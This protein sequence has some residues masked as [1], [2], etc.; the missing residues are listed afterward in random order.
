MG[1]NQMIYRGAI[2][3]HSTHSYDGKST[4]NE[5]KKKAV[6]LGLDFIALTEHIENLDDESVNVYLRECE[7][8]SDE[9]FLI[10]PGFEYSEFKDHILAIGFKKLFRN[11]T[12]L[13]LI[14]YAK[15][16]D[17]IVILAHPKKEGYFVDS[18]VLEN[19]DGLEIWN[20]KYDGIAPNNKSIEI[21]NGDTLAFGGNDLHSSYEMGGITYEVDAEKLGETYILKALKMG[22]YTFGNFLFRV[23]PTPKK[24]HTYSI[25][26]ILN[27][28]YHKLLNL[29]G[30]IFRLSGLSPSKEISSKI[31]NLL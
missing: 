28:I 9:K 24:S 23:G 10:I 2:H 13:E 15:K 11:L 3:I 7:K 16:L 27:Q 4:L 8:L 6:F 22:K 30:K 1:E 29:I 26:N 19:I 20:R 12:E 5:L 31:R 18:K 21:L 17:S 25:F 14:K